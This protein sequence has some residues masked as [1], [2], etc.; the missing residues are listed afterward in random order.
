MIRSL[1]I[2]DE[3][4]SAGILQKL[5]QEVSIEVE[6]LAI[7]HS[8]KNGLKAIAE[9]QPELVFLDIQFPIGT[10]FD[11]LDQ[12]DEVNFAV[13]F[14]TAYDSYALQA[15]KFS[16]LD[17]LLKPIDKIELKAAIEKTIAKQAHSDIQK[18][19]VELLIQNLLQG[20]DHKNKK[21][22]Q[23]IALP[24]LKGYSFIKVDDILYC[25]AEGTYTKI[26][27]SSRPSIL[28]SRNLKNL[29]GLLEAYSFFRVHRS[30]LVNINHIMEYV[31][32]PGG[33]LH[34]NNGKVIPVSQGR[35]DVFIS[36]LFG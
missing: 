19:K 33:E 8:I 16:A 25:E 34:L 29:E 9:L 22:A 14:T 23:K 36:Y 5:I 3:T 12:I 31:K 24:T 26:H 13:I 17:Y 18:Q 10:G 1:I 11:L 35:K 4:R 28:I 32:G 6:I 2:E 27:F 15:I 21:N 30:F 20:M 7:E